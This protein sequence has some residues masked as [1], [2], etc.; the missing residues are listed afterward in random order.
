MARSEGQ[1][2]KLLCLA[3][4][5]AEQTDDQNTMTAQD[6][7]KAL[8]ARGIK[9]ER[10]SIYTD[11]EL[12]RQFGMDI[13]INKGKTP[14]YFVASR[15]FELPELKLLV[16]AVTS[17]RFIT[18]KKSRTLIKK[19]S[20]LTSKP[21]AHQLDRQVF[22]TGRAKTFNEAVYYTIDTIHTAINESKKIS[23]KYFSYDIKKERIYRKSGEP[24]IRTPVAL[25]WSED[26]Y[27]LITYYPKQDDSFAHFRVDRM[28]EARI[29]DE[30]RDGFDKEEFSVAGHA[31]RMF[32]MYTGETTQAKLA[33]DNSLVSIVLD[34]FGGDIRLSDNGDGRFTI[35]VE[36]SESPVFFGWIFQLGKQ[37]EI[38]APESLRQAMRK[39]LKEAAGNYTGQHK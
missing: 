38:L 33:F 5:L 27:Y 1:K 28:S 23:F 12:L 9:A 8:A 15:D 2:L 22:I 34:H 6:L 16:D 14:G 18:G 21:Q 25:C 7:I 32:G 13:E 17:S 10:K 39:L 11:I 26:N 3:Q 36:I 4:I 30:A 19:L 29:L 20:A 24:Y 35:S 37:A 31:K